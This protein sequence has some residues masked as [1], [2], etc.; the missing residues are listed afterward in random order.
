MFPPGKNRVT[1]PPPP[2]RPHMTTGP[3]PAPARRTRPPGVCRESYEYIIRDVFHYDL[4]SILAQALD[5]YGCN[6]YADFVSMRIS[7]IEDLVYPQSQTP[8]ENGQS[9]PPI[10]TP[11]PKTLKALVRGFLGYIYHR[12]YVLKDPINAYNCMQIDHDLFMCYR[13]SAECLVFNNSTISQLL[14]FKASRLTPAEYF[15]KKLQLDPSYFPTFSNDKQWDSF[16]LE[17]K[18]LCRVHNLHKVLNPAYKPSTVDDKDLFD[19]HQAFLYMVFVKTLLTDKGKQLVREYQTTYDAQTIYKLLS[20]TYNES[21]KAD[22]SAND[23]LTW[24]IYTK[25]ESMLDQWM[26]E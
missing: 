21:I 2:R 12:H 24:L 25:R 6:S 1:P 18:A 9:R 11:L 8:N 7:D 4:D 3:P 19:R 5:H 20:Q 13:C 17:L 14:I 16:N 26:L 15:D 10:Y 22:T 23:K